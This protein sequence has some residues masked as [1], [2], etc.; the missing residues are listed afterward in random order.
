MD[1]KFIVDSRVQ[2]PVIDIRFFYVFG[3][4]L[5]S[6]FPSYGKSLDLPV[7]KDRS[8]SVS[9]RFQVAEHVVHS[10]LFHF[11]QF[12]FVSRYFLSCVKLRNESHGI[13][14]HVGGHRHVFVFEIFLEIIQVIFLAVI[15]S[16]LEIF[17]ILCQINIVVVWPVIFKLYFRASF[18]YHIQH[19]DRNQPEAERIPFFLEDLFTAING[20]P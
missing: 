8:C 7:D 16:A 19:M 3:N 2:S 11:E 5:F 17:K 20:F 14:R 13:I 12:H 18:F 1:A 15:S 4:S 6:Q 9:R 10:T